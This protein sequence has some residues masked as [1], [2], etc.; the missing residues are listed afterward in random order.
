[1]ADRTKIKSARVEMYLDAISGPFELSISVASL[2]QAVA[3]LSARV[4][5]TPVGYLMEGHPGVLACEVLEQ[6]ADQFKRALATDANGRAAEPGTMLPTHV[7]RLHNP[8]DGDVTENDIVFPAA[9][10]MNFGMAKA[11]TGPGGYT[12]D[13]MLVKPTT[14]D[15]PDYWVGYT[16]P[17]EPDGGTGVEPDQPL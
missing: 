3:V 14:A 1:M 17:A 8:A 10:F 12:F 9:V 4:G 5:A 11:A 6:S 16:A 13:L 2:N 15:T 7:V